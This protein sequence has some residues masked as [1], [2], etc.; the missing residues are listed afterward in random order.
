[1]MK[2]Y[3]MTEIVRGLSSTDLPEIRQNVYTEAE[4][5]WRTTP[6]HGSFSSIHS[7]LGG[8]SAKR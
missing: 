8:K 1:M 5:K 7:P 4:E 3:G 6:I 2:K